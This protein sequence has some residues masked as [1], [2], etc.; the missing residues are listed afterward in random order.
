MDKK[1]E[2]KNK[3]SKIGMIFVGLIIIIGLI[4]TYYQVKSKNLFVKFQGFKGVVAIIGIILL[5]LVF[6][7]LHFFRYGYNLAK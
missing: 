4:N 2:E 6:I 5:L 3:N 1:E 7:Y